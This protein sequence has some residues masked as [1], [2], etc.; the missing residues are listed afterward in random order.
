MGSERLKVHPNL[1]YDDPRNAGK[2]LYLVALVHDEE[3]SSKGIQEWQEAA[4]AFYYELMRAKRDLAPR[5]SKLED[6]GNILQPD[7]ILKNV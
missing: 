7:R 3:T 4:F 5:L 6:K 1:G 2:A